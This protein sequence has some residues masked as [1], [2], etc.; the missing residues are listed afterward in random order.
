MASHGRKSDR[1]RFEFGYAARIMGID[2]TWQ[3]DCMIDDIS[4]TGSKFFV[5]GSIT[6][7]NLDEFFLILSSTGTAHRRCRLVRINGDE[8]GVKFIQSE[9]AAKDRF[10]RN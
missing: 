6:G 3:R 9:T 4:A 8:I 5:T 2:G 1:V 7:L 10:K